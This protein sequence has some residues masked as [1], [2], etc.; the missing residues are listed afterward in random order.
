[1]TPMGSLNAS[2]TFVEMA[3][4]L[5]MEWEKL[6]EGRGIKNVSKIIVDDVLLYGRTTKQLQA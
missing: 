5:Q 4:K 1:M 2:T 3:M 6:D